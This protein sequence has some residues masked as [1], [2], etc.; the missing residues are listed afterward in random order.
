MLIDTGSQISLINSE[1]IKDHSLI[2][3]NNRINIS[4]I[5]GTESTLGNINTFIN[6]NNMK[7]PIQ[8]QVT[9]N[10]SL[11]QNGIIGYDFLGEKAII[12]GPKNI[13]MINSKE[14]N[15]EIPIKQNSLDHRKVNK[16]DI[17]KEI[18]SFNKIEYLDEKE[19]NLQYKFNLQQVKT[20][21]HQLTETK[22]T[23]QSQTNK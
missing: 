20:I 22:I 18:D 9:N 12:N 19:M 1:K 5:H 11:R 6:T 21:T 2:D 15:I 16:I 3:K 7:I 13:V 4:S 14:G 17:N 23:I 8:L 10:S